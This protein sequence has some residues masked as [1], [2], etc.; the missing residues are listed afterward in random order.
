M[1][2]SR[3]QSNCLGLF[4]LAT[5]LAYSASLDTSTSPVSIPLVSAAVYI[6]NSNG[7]SASASADGITFSIGSPCTF[8]SS[9][10]KGAFAAAIATT[11]C[12]NMSTKTLR[13][14][15]QHAYSTCNIAYD[16]S[17]SIFAAALSGSDCTNFDV[18]ANHSPFV[19]EGNII[20]S[21]F[22]IVYDFISQLSSQFS[23]VST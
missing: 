11:D 23:K 9:D 4:A 8:A 1:R 12:D 21:F 17:G 6:D 18:E 10:D 14:N 19:R 20:S 7:G 22:T 5:I 13:A 3:S 16:R 2:L 15:P